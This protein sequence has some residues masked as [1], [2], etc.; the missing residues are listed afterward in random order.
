M[1][2]DRVP[3]ATKLA[4]SMVILFSVSLI[5]SL[6]AA[7]EA[8]PLHP[9]Y[10]RCASFGPEGPDPEMTPPISRPPGLLNPAEALDLVG[11]KTA[12][13]ERIG[14]RGTTLVWFLVDAKSVLR[15]VRIA[16]TSGFVRVDS[17]ALDVART[18]RFQAATLNGKAVCVW[19]AR[20][21]RFGPG[22]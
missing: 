19:V 5:P 15:D 14:D 9:D 21:L 7:Q 3:C 2:R 12:E 11:K 1:I 17:A 6:A 10:T 20:P 4:C 22:G 18:L 16:R 13:L 8:V